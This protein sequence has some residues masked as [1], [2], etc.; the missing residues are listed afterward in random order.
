[1]RAVVRQIFD[2]ISGV[3]YFAARARHL[4]DMIT[5]IETRMQYWENYKPAPVVEVVKAVEIVE[6]EVPAELIESLMQL[7]SNST[8]INGR[9]GQAVT[10]FIPAET[11]ERLR[12]N[13]AK[14][15]LF[16]D[17]VAKQLVRRALYGVWHAQAGAVEFPVVT[18]NPIITQP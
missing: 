6:T 9:T 1:M 7:R 12:P 2:W 14:Q 3:F 17:R 13:A 4:A 11:L 18:S 15:R 10:V 16:T 5:N 8:S